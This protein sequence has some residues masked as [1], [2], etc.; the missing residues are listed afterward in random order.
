[1]MAPV[2]R[3]DKAELSLRR[4]HAVAVEAGGVSGTQ[5]PGFRR[6]EL[7]NFAQSDV[8]QTWI[9]RDDV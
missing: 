4:D 8:S 3:I 9:S 7:G 6:F 5:L 2:S 1:M